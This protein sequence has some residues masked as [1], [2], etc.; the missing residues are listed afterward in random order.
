MIRKITV[1]RD[2]SVYEAWPDVT[3]TQS[4]K[5]LAVFTECEH[6]LDRNRSRL[7][8]KESF[9]D[10]ETWGEKIRFTPIAEKKPG[11]TF[12]FF[13]CARVGTLSGNRSYVICDKISGDESSK[14]EIY[15]WLSYDEGKKWNEPIRVPLCGIVPDKI[16]ELDSGR[17]LVSAHFKSATSGKLVQ[18][19]VYSDDGMKT[20][21][22]PVV[23]AS[24]PRYNLCEVSVLPCGD[25]LVA[26]L[27]ENS[28]IG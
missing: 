5:L 6:H 25:T 10:G 2:E 27:R 20:W 12:S 16:T 28:N 1:S 19:L 7:V 8:L 11:E 17:L 4:G 3:R 26:F 9:D 21:S 14:A 23:V 15:V 13:N 24:D 22:D 18:Y